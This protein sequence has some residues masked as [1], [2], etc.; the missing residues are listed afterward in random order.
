MV[1]DGM[2]LDFFSRDGPDN[3]SGVV[4]NESL[5]RSRPKL[6]TLLLDIRQEKGKGKN[7]KEEEKKRKRKVVAKE[8]TPSF[9]LV[10]FSCATKIALRLLAN[11]GSQMTWSGH[12]FEWF[13]FSLFIFAAQ[14]GKSFLS[15]SCNT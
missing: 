9:Y 10:F 12:Q 3:K 2:G 13:L 15:D 7:D 14:R 8:C 4:S 1:I 11:Y 6:S 5:L